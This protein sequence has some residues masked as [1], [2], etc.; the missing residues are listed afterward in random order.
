MAAGSARG[1]S[2]GRFSMHDIHGQNYHDIRLV[3]RL[4]VNVRV[5]V[6]CMCVYVCVSGDAYGRACLCTEVIC[7]W[8]N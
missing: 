6:G 4:C 8:H 2:V 5:C 3:S 7:T 1:C